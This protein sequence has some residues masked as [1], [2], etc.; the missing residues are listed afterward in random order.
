MELQSELLGLNSTL[1]QFTELEPE[2]A[3]LN[4]TLEQFAEIKDSKMI[5]WHIAVVYGN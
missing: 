4:G 3:G 2:L 5:E 1:K